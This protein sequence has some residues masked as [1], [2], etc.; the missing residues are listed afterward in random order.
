MSRRSTHIRSLHR[1]HYTAAEDGDGGNVQTS[2]V[3][4]ERNV[5]NNGYTNMDVESVNNS[6]EHI[7]EGNEATTITN[8]DDRRRKASALTPTNTN[9]RSSRRRCSTTNNDNIVTPTNGNYT[10]TN[11]D[12]RTIVCHV[13]WQYRGALH[14]HRI[15]SPNQQYDMAAEEFENNNKI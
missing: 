6:P 1:R 13:E 11:T 5:R 9:Y 7:D 15:F 10:S 8:N 4:K 3:M 2:N 14:T 12:I